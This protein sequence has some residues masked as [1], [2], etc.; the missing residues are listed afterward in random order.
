LEH[1]NFRQAGFIDNQRH[2]IIT[3]DQ[4][5][6]S[7]LSEKQILLS[8]RA[9]MYLFNIPDFQLV[10]ESA[11]IIRTH[12]VWTHN[13][14]SLDVYMYPN[15]SPP[16]GGQTATVA[17]LN[18]YNLRVFHADL[19]HSTECRVTSYS[20]QTHDPPRVHARNCLSSKRVFFCKDNMLQTCAIPAEQGLRDEPLQ[21]GKLSSELHSLNTKSVVVNEATV[22]G[23]L[24]VQDISWDE[25]SGR[26]CLLTGQHHDYE[27]LQRFP[28]QI[29]VVDF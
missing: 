26:L 12:P 18:G 27:T 14:E 5:T 1:S 6:I 2:H 20:L 13:F 3:F 28:L 23:K 8:S 9:G 25:A 4:G 17:V 10:S 7:I 16:D 22:E 15:T 21:A 29:V 19:Q 11:S 24:R